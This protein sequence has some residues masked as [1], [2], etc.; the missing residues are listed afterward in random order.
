[1]ITGVPL[2]ISM[3][4]LVE[5]LRVHNSAVK[6]AKR[7][8]RRMEQRETEEILKDLYFGYVRYIVREFLKTNEMFQMP[9]IWAYH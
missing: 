6:M 8:T 3:R 5:Y 2:S 1:M 7:M 9:G 4:E